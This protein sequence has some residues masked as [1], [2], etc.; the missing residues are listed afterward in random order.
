MI[1][2]RGLRLAVGGLV[3][4]ASRPR[5]ALRFV[6]TRLGRYARAWRNRGS[7]EES[8][9][10]GLDRA[11][12]VLSHVAVLPGARKSGVGRGLVS[13]FADASLEAGADR[14]TLVTLEDQD[15]AGAFYA[16]LGWTPGDIRSTPEGRRL[17]EWSISLP[18]PQQP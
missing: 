7:R 12:A 4:L 18:Q 13:A 2:R 11:P 6:T 9:Q 17:R 5:S 14:A 15:G 1:R 10:A 8:G 3:A 16:G